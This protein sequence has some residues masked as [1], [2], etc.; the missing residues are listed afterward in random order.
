MISIYMYRNTAINMLNIMLVRLAAYLWTTV[1][2]DKSSS[3]ASISR[4]SPK[5]C[6]FINRIWRGTHI[7]KL[8]STDDKENASLWN[9]LIC[10]ESAQFPKSLKGNVCFSRNLQY[11]IY[12]I[13]WCIF[14]VISTFRQFRIDYNK[15]E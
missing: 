8:K 2:F 1:W 14:N 3:S 4:Y 6:L 10:I 5:N 15:L 13:A 12:A 7:G 11:D 9:N